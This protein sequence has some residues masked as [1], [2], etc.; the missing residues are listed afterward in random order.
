MRMLRSFRTSLRRLIRGGF[1]LAMLP[2]GLMCPQPSIVSHARPLQLDLKLLAHP[3]TGDPD[4]A[5]RGIGG[6]ALRDRERPI[7]DRLHW[8]F[9]GDLRSVVRPEVRQ[10]HRPAPVGQAVRHGWH[11]DPCDHE[12]ARDVRGRL[13][14]AVRAPAREHNEAS[15]RARGRRRQGVQL[16]RE[17]RC[18]GAV[19][20][21]AYIPFRSTRSTFS[22]R[23]KCPISAREKDPGK[24]AGCRGRSELLM[25]RRSA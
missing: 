22:A 2:C 17:S 10:A 9:Y 4:L 8:C 21:E 19:G 18:A 13:P 3:S 16:R 14:A 11:S 6:A 25:G 20:I 1:D 7:F 15:R 24:E 23:Q 5:H 12:C